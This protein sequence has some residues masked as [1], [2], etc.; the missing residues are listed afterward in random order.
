MDY[1]IY[2]LFRHCILVRLTER[3]VNGLRGVNATARVA[4]EPAKEGGNV[5]A[6]LRLMADLNV[7][8]NVTKQ[9]IVY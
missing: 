2:I 3:L 4:L 9:A 8:A 1:S 6:H 5:T 7:S